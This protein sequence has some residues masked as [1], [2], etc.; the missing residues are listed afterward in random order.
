MNFSVKINVGF[1][2]YRLSGFAVF[3]P[4]LAVFPFYVPLNHIFSK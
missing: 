1:V 2:F 4:N 3:R